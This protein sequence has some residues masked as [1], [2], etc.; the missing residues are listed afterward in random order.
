[1]P[2][3]LNC[4]L[5]EIN[6]HFS[7]AKWEGPLIQLLPSFKLST[8]GNPES[9]MSSSWSVGVSE[10]ILCLRCAPRG[11]AF[12]LFVILDELKN[13]GGTISCAELLSTD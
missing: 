12:C 3:E 5:S 10:S 7:L 9:V 2:V 4:Y 11:V 8:E 1:M 13:G 6:V